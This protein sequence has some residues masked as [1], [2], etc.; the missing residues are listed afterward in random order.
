MDSQKEQNTKISL[1]EEIDLLEL[2]SKVISKWKFI[3]K[4]TICF[5]VLGFVM[6]LSTIKEYTAE[7]MVAPESSSSSVMSSGLGSL[8]SLAGF[9]LGSMAGSDDAIYPQLYPDIIQSLPF[10]SSLFDVNVKSLDGS[11]DT[12]Y[13]FYMKELQKTNWIKVV[14]SAPKKAIEWAMGLLSSDEEMG[15]EGL[16]NPYNLSKKQMIMIDE[17]N[18]AISISVDKQTNVITLSYT[19]QDP[20]IAATMVDTIMCRLQEKITAYRTQ[21]ALADCAYIEKLYLESKNE[22]EKAQETYAMYVDRNRNV[23]QERFLVERERLSADKD[24]KNTLY[25]QWAQQL[26]LAKAKVQEYTPAFTTLKPAVVPAI[27]SSMRK[28][29]VIFIYTFLG[30]VLAV[31]YVLLKDDAIN[32]LQEL[33]GRKKSATQLEDTEH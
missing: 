5:I 27:P 21:K 32:V 26:Q 22:Y 14:T 11:I 1:Q 24:L 8:A 3:L 13:Y 18:E 9:D 16:F 25:T 2:A 31:T 7:I 33:F 10:L 15:E 29:M 19:D 17:L 12:T 4:F 30:F 6:A 28:L 20:L 23:T